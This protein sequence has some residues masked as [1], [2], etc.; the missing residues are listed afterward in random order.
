M[1]LPS[2]PILIALATLTT[3]PSSVVQSSLTLPEASMTKARSMIQLGSSERKEK[4]NINES[5]FKFLY[6]FTKLQ[7]RMFYSPLGKNQL[8]AHR[9]WPLKRGFPKYSMY[10][11][12]N[13][14]C[15]HML[16]RLCISQ[17]QVHPA[18]PPPSA[19]APGNLPFFSYGRLIP[20]GRGT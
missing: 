9:G 8:T 7:S 1:W 3:K 16:Y 5:S 2:G 20:G 10:C 6:L 14:T 11:G 17:Y 15:M 13:G 19:L 18:P 12:K 4:A